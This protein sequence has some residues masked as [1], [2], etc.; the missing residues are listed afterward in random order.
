MTAIVSTSML[1]TCMPIPME[2]GR[3]R[4]VWWLH[5]R[6]ML[7]WL[8]PGHFFW[9]MHPSAV[10]Q[11]PH[12]T[13]NC[14][15][16]SVWHNTMPCPLLYNILQSFLP[17]CTCTDR[18]TGM[19]VKSLPWHFLPNQSYQ[20]AFLS[21]CSSLLLMPPADRTG[22]HLLPAWEH[23]PP[24]YAIDIIDFLQII[25]AFPGLSLL[26]DFGQTRVM[27]IPRHYSYYRS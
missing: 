22:I 3:S 16:H 15:Y 26:S 2:H 25:Q 13:G 24:P 14:S 8:P 11:A 10:P 12:K 19:P 23:D 7:R 5:A 27:Q 6:M 17:V 9:P 4:I 1:T 21:A 18:R 20:T